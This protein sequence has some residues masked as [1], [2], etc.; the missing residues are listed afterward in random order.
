MRDDTLGRMLRRGAVEPG[1][2]P[3]IGGINAALDTL[4]SVPI[5]AEEA[6]RAVVSDDGREIRLTLYAEAGAVAT[7]ALDPVRAVALAGRL[8]AAARAPAFF[9]DR[10]TPIPVTTWPDESTR[11]PNSACVWIAEATVDG[12]LYVARS[13]HGAPNELARQLVAAGVADRQMVIRSRGLAGT[14]TYRSFYAAAGWT[15]SEGDQPLRRVRYREQPEGLFLVCGDAQKCVSSP[16]ADVWA[17]Q[18]SF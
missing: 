9:E 15:Y 2:L 3:L 4:D 13:R 8:I 11:T 17:R 6:A 1:Q 10:M 7:V 14:M 18:A 5:E 16:K 12:R